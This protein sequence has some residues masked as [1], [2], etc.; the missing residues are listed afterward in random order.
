[1]RIHYDPVAVNDPKLDRMRTLVTAI[2]KV[3]DERLSI[4]DFR[5]V[6]GSGHTN[7][8]F[9]V[10]LPVDLR[11]QEKTIQ[12]AL[13]TALNDLGEE[14]FYTVITFDHAAFN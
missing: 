5:L 2:L 10:A 3:R 6:P 11:G 1:M 8:I 13:E 14:T 7:L 12:A 4:H 9:D